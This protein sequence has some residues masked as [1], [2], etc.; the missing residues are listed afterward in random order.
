[1][2]RFR[3]IS[4]APHY[5]ATFI[6]RKGDPEELKGRIGLAGVAAPENM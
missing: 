3:M 2:V 1:M 6:V 5:E 4:T